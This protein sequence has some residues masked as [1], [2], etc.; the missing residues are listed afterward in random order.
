MFRAAA[1]EPTDEMA[2]TCGWSMRDSTVSFAPCTTLK[3]PSG[4]PA[5]EKNSARRKAES[6]VRWEGLRIKVLPVAIA[7]GANHSGII[8]G[9][10]NGVMA[11]TT[12]KGSLYRATST[13]WLT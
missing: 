9:K 2:L 7:K 5:S 6:G 12:P 10:L 13:P 4:K 8:T 11:V 3:T 1:E